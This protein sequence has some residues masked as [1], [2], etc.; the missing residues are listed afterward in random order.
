MIVTKNWLNEFVDLSDITA[1]EVAK[2]FISIGFEVEEMK[3]LSKG[4]EKVRIGKIEKITRHPNADRLQVCHINLGDSYVQIITAAT[5]VFEGALVP[6]AL[7]GANLPNGLSIKT[8]NMRGEQSQGMLCAGSELK[9]NKNVYPTAEVDGIMILDDSAKLGQ[10]IAEFLN[11][12]DVV[13]DLKVLPNRPDCQSVVGL[14]RELSVYFKKQFNFVCEKIQN[15]KNVPLKI[16]VQTPNC[17]LYFGTVLTNV[18]I[19][20]S[21]LVIR[22]RLNAV[23]VATHNT[24]VDLTNYILYEIGQPLHAFDYDNIENNHIIV[25]PA[26]E[27]EQI[28]GFDNELRQLNDNIT[29]IADESKPIGIAGIMGGKDFSIK[30]DTK[31]VVLESAIFDRVNI[32]RGSRSLGLRTEASARYERG[33]ET[34]LAKIG[35]ERA[36]YLIK[37][38]NIATICNTIQVGNVN[39]STR[40]I[41]LT[42]NEIK[43]TLGIVVPTEN[44]LDI[45]NRLEIQTTFDNEKFTCVIP[46]IRADIENGADLIEEIIRFYGYE[47][48]VPTRNEKTDCTVGGM[49]PQLSLEYE[50]KNLMQSVGACEV[51]TYT[52]SSFE[53]LDKLCL[54]S[55][56]VLRNCVKISNPLSSEYCLMRS[57]MLSSL[58][59]VVALN[60]ARGNYNFQI[61]EIG[62][63]FDGSKV[64]S[65][66]VNLEKKILSYITSE[67]VN[68]FDV[69]AIVEM[70]ASRLNLTFDYK[71]ASYTFMHPNICANIVIGNRVVG[72]IGKVHPKV[73]LNFNL[74][75]DCYYFELDLSLLPPKKFKKVKDVNKYPS[76]LR[77]ISIVVDSSVQ[78]GLL[79]SAIKKAGGKDLESAELFDIYEGNQVGEN[80][81]SVA[82]KLTFRSETHTLAMSE[83][84]EI[85]DNILAFLTKEYGAELRA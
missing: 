63:V 30:N 57:Q 77:D 40:T 67:K 43:S 33:V 35:L 85:F 55:D 20:N 54:D 29:V 56:D 5:N 24:M 53:D 14:A 21:P 72:K 41:T 26:K 22:N 10:N 1:D 4:M 23:G 75:N 9:I 83:V 25:R 66:G 34:I 84:N 70:L 82:F 79:L 6:C 74:K 46:S 60:N 73:A 65:N 58:L 2:A 42:H 18:K 32:R 80:K 17:Q 36:L 61:F 64:N 47:K 50:L 38:Y 28:L 39:E 62:K 51:K 8:S 31:N 19:E 49:S 11:L 52:F 44:V 59:N 68:F 15:D 27:N 3:D 12:N 76:A 78:V 48:I 16:D 81:K 7:D 13:Y 71:V 45:L 69:K 37:K